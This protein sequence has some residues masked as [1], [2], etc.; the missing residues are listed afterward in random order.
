MSALFYRQY[1]SH[2]RLAQLY[3]AT[4]STSNMIVQLRSESLEGLNSTGETTI[5]EVTPARVTLL[6]HSFV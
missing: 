2:G 4:T 5:D 6:Q 3:R 1:F